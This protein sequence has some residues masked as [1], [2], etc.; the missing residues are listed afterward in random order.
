[1]DVR[2]CACFGRKC[3][4][5]TD[6]PIVASAEIAGHIPVAQGTVA[7]WA[8]EPT[9]PQPLAELRGGAV[10]WWPEQAVWIRENRGYETT[11]IDIPRPVGLDLVGTSEI[12]ARCKVSSAA[13]ANWRARYPS[14]PKPLVYLRMGPV[15][16]WDPI[17]DWVANRGT[18]SRVV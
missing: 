4:C 14:F 8:K 10:Y 6:M 11:S 2:E 1:M 15:H 12:A 3:E 18:Y 17:P 16:L 9:W 5:V 13:V 7:L